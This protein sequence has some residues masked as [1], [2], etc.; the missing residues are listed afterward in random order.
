VTSE[1]EEYLPN[2]KLST[3]TAGMLKRLKPYK[4][5]YKNEEVP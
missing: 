3:I 1:V 2:S 4:G 5:F